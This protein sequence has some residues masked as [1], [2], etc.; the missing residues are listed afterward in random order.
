MGKRTNKNEKQSLYD[1]VIL[2][3]LEKWPTMPLLQL[4]R[5][6]YNDNPEVFK[7]VEHVRSLIRYRKSKSGRYNRS[8]S[9]KNYKE[10]KTENGEE[11]KKAGIGNPLYTLPESEA[12]EWPPYVMPKGA[13]RVLV[14][15]DIHIPY[16]DVE[17]LKTAVN[18]GKEKEANTVLL[19]GDILD[20]YALSRWEK[21]P[22]KRGFS[23]ELAD[24]RQFLRWLKQELPNAKIYFKLGNHEERYEK[25]L[26]IKAPELLDVSEFRLDILLRFGELGIE[27]IDE[28]RIVQLGKLIVMHGHEFGRSV[29]SPV[30]PARGY[31][32]RAKANILAG[33]NHQTSHHMEKNLKGEVVSAWSTGCLSELHP[34]YARVNKWNLGFAFVEV[35]KDGTFEVDNLAI[36][37][38]KIR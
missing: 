19:N 5:K 11:A 20:C 10:Y 25:F 7:D 21:D 8:F 30:N 13:S 36:I 16:H 1:S 31:Y 12:E 37:N 24:T 14:L 9:S 22:R 28:Q 29:F 18:Y 2:P 35:F 17:A 33:H 3:H 15:S 26:R 38:G 32:M 27:L 23:G 4:A 6:I 34:Q